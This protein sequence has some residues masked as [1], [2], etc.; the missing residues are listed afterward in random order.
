MVE[1]VVI[2][3][4]FSSRA[5]VVSGDRYQFLLRLLPKEKYPLVELV[6]NANYTQGM[7]S[8]VLTG[9]REVRASG[10]FPDRSY[11]GID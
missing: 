2:A 10:T 5:I 9:F 6:Y 4:G 7:F 1:G 3:D 11:C 8:S